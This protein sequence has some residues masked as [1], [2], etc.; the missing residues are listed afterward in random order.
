MRFSR[1]TPGLLLLLSGLSGCSHTG[2]FRSPPPDDIKTIA[3]IGDKALPIVA[4]AP[5]NSLR[6]DTAGPDLPRSSRGRISG[7]V[8]D[9]EGRPV[10]NARVRLALGAA[11]AGKAVYAN[12]DR[13]GAFTLAGLRPGSDYTVIAE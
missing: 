4:G 13:S 12:T 2:A 3:S 11:P 5:G 6:A 7:R 10:P 1:V 9:E 8:Y